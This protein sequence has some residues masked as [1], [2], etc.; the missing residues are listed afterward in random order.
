[1][2][3]IHNR[4]NLILRSTVL[5][6][7]I[8][9]LATATASANHGP[10]TSGG[11]L[12]TISGETLKASK[13]DMSFRLD[14]TDFDGVSAAVAE[15]RAETSGEF[16][17]I[18]RSTL[19]NLSLNYGVT[20]DLQIGAAI[21]WYWGD[22]FIDAHFDPADGHAHSAT[23][24]PS[25][26]T[27]LWITAKYRVM[28]GEDGH[29]S[30]LGGIKLPTGEDGELLSD[31]EPLEPSSQPGS[32]S[33]DFLAGVAYSRFLTS[34]LTLDASAS[35]TFRTEA[36]DFKV[37]DRFDAGLAINWRLTD[38]IDT[39]PNI[40]LFGEIAF[41]TL[42]KDESAGVAN[43]N[44]GGST[45]YLAPGVR[46][47]INS[48]MALSVAPQFPVWQDLNGEQVETDYKVTALLSLTF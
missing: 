46:A 15:E 24:D 9:T 12:T 39:F 48:T 16:D 13:W 17:S 35:Y 5:A 26:L 7:F 10:G 42:M 30:L 2:N 29:L 43:E 23:A 38:A 31:G 45:L 4:Q 8:A 27:D 18:D 14:F 3:T 28:K 41:T 1:M 25:G 37:G 40:S 47:R 19:A 6:G 20:D 36:N 34:H 44:S 33:W 11:G 21:G 22:N 32:G